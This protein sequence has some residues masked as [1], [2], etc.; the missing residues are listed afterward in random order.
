MN[1]FNPEKQKQLLD[2]IDFN[3]LNESTLETLKKNKH[4]PSDLI[5]EAALNLCKKLRK[6]LDDAKSQLKSQETYRSRPLTTS[7]PT[8]YVSDSISKPSYNSY[9]SKYS[10]PSK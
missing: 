7:V 3:K 10:S 6:E 4:I 2:L 9:S 1:L 8:S 5:V